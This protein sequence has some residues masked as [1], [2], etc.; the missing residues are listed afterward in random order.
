MRTPVTLEWSPVTVTGLTL[1]RDAV[2]V[3]APY[4]SC[5]FA[6]LS[7]RLPGVWSLRMMPQGHAGPVGY[8][9]FKSKAAAI[10]HAQRWADHHG[11]KLPPFA[12]GLRHNPAARQ[13]HPDSRR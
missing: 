12:N 8:V 5:C 3:V 2:R 9:D 11:H 7:L 6:T 10:R 4:E 1:D 13:D